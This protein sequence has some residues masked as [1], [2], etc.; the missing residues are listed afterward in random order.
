[1]KNGINKYILIPL[2]VLVFSFTASVFASPEPDVQTPQIKTNE[3]IAEEVSQKCSTGTLLFSEG[4]CLTIRV[5]TW[6]PFT[7][8]AIV[9][10]ESGQPVVYDSTNGI[11]VRRLALDNYLKGEGYSSSNVVVMNPVKPLTPEQQEK[12]N[13]YLDSQLGKPYAL[14]QF[15]IGSGHEGIHCSEY[16][17]AALRESDII[18]VNRPEKVSPASLYEGV[19]SSSLYNIGLVSQLIRPVI[20]RGKGDSWYHQA[21]LDTKFC[22]NKCHFKLATWT[23]KGR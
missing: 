5:Y 21:W 20:K 22:Y 11:G 4:D 15:I 1:M 18:K 17:S 23:M 7:H 14:K 2:I 6:S 8:V 16:V 13:S 19:N 9:V 12:L 10:M 3:A